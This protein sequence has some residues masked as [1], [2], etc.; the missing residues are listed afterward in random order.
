[1]VYLDMRDPNTNCPT[2]WRLIPYSKRTCGKVIIS[3]LS[4]DSVFFPVTGGHYNRVCGTIRAYQYGRTDAFEAY[5]D[6]SVTTIDGAY[7]AGVSLT[8]GTPRQHIWTFAAG[9]GENRPTMDDSCPCDATINIDIPPFVGQDYFCESGVNSGF[10]T[11]FHPDD[12]LWDGEGCS[13]TSTCCELNN[14]PYFIKQ[15]SS[16]TT[17][18]IEARICQ[19]DIFD[20]TPIEFIELYVM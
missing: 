19:L 20:D 14:P 17:D 11:G 16:P 10:A 3:G 18:D 1:M 5:H 2:G 9:G 12:P 13:S 4:C 8:H 6:G 7:V 15:L